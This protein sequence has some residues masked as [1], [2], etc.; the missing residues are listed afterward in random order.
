M[1]SEGDTAPDF[2][3]PGTDGEDVRLYAL[4]D[5]L[6]RG[7]VVV[8]FYLFDFHPAC[9]EQV[10]AIRDLDWFE[11]MPDATAVAISTDSA[12]SHRAFARE[13]DFGF[14]LLSDDTGTVADAYGVLSEDVADHGLVPRRSVFVVDTDWTVRHAW[15]SENPE[16]VPDFDPVKTTLESLG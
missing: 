7:P 16:T 12:Y 9:T 5:L 8:A 2:V 13:H 11:F 1:L 4:T 6:Q 15:A 3:L 10:C 14:P